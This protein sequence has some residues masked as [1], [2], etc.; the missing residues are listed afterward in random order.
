MSAYVVDPIT[1]RR[2]LS[3]LRAQAKR[4]SWTLERINAI[5]KPTE[6]TIDGDPQDVGQAM[7]NL[8]VNAVGQRY[9]HSK[10][11]NDLP[12]TYTDGENLD[13]FTWETVYDV[14]LMQA[15]KSLQCWLYQCAEGNVTET[16][17]YKAFTTILNQWAHEIVG[18]TKEYD[19]AKWE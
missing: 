15:Y 2:I 12:G 4:E 17:M 10:G 1:I 3:K 5:L 18:A 11:V 9:E 8:N 19:K 13:T 16:A 7:Y 14:S 6:F